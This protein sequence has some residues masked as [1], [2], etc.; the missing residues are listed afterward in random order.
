MP[1]FCAI[2]TSSPIRTRLREVKAEE[3]KVLGAI[4]RAMEGV[5]LIDIT[6]EYDGADPLRFTGQV[7]GD[8]ERVFVDPENFGEIIGKDLPKDKVYVFVCRR[9]RLS[10]QVAKVFRRRGYEAYYDALEV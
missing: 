2:A 9:G 3:E 4:E 1:E 10:R 7:E 6:K 5:R 8:V